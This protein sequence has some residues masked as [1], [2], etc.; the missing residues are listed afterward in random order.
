MADATSTTMLIVSDSGC[1]CCKPEVKTVDDVIREL[2]RRRDAL[3][4]RLAGIGAR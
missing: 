4:A 3:D 1:G 2:E